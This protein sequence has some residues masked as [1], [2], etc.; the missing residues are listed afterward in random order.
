MVLSVPEGDDVPEKF[1]NMFER[2]DALLITKADEMPFYAFNME[3]VIRQVKQLNPDIHIFQ[4]SSKYG[5]GI[6]D[7]ELW[8]LKEARA[9]R[10]S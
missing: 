3:K 2:C 6:G 5:E 7:F 9:W 10:Q 8:L 4:I 1:P